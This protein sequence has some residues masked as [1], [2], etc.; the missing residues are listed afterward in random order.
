MKRNPLPATLDDRVPP[1]HAGVHRPIEEGKVPRIPRHRQSPGFLTPGRLYHV[2]NRGVDRSIIFTSDRDRIVFLSLLA[3]ACLADEL[4]CHAWC[5]MSNHFHLVVEDTRGMLSQMMHHLQFCYARYFN[6]TRLQRRTGPLFESR[7]RA[8]MIDSAAYFHEAVA[9][10]LLNPVR[11]TKPLARSAESYRWSS[12]A[13]VCTNTSPAAFCTGLLAEFGGVEGVLAALPRARNRVSQERRRFR[14]EAL[15]SGAWMSRESV[16]SGRTP[17]LYLGFLA[18]RAINKQTSPMNRESLSTAVADV[19]LLSPRIDALALSRPQF[20]GVELE[21]AIDAITDVCHRIVPGASDG[22]ADQLAE[23]VAYALWRFTAASA[24]SIS[25]A[26]G[27]ATA[28][29]VEQILAV[30]LARE[31]VTGWKW[32]LQS[33]EWTLRWQLRAAP[34]RL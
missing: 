2:T 17:D 3:E 12:A 33:V 31:G 25:R 22:C 5:L 9:Y 13:L 16:L 24:E 7:F 21:Q 8:E 20:C 19:A 6:D 18:A 15:L 34:H 14:L 28:V 23:V 32:L 26:V 1:F 11:T 30:R 29:V 10:V 27:R 4:V